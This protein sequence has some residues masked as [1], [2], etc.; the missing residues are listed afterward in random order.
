ML[1]LTGRVRDACED[2]IA[3]YRGADVNE[4]HPLL[5]HG[6]CPDGNILLVDDSRLRDGPARARHRCRPRMWRPRCEIEDNVLLPGAGRPRAPR[7]S[8]GAE[9]AAGGSG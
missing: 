7:Q 6:F 3:G 1:G 9:A 2:A 5:T 4:F 8:R